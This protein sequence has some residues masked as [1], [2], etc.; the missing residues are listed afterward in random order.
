MTTLDRI[1]Y[2]QVL[3][4]RGLL[5]LTCT[6]KLVN[7]LHQR[8]VIQWVCIL[9]ILNIWNF[10]FLVFSFRLCLF[11]AISRRIIFITFQFC[12]LIYWMRSGFRALD[13]FILIVD[14]CV[15]SL[16]L[17]FCWRILSWHIIILTVLIKICI[18]E[19]Y[20]F[21]VEKGVLPF[22]HF[23]IQVGFLF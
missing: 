13:K 8:A 21:G 6:K 7:C 1:N 23:V 12:V 3:T 16:V 17:P 22:A 14:I 5:I 20:I 11:L 10:F 9:L 15:C 18:F 2:V 19:T 4:G